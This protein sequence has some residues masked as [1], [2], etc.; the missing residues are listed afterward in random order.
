VKYLSSI[1]G[2]INHGDEE[3]GSTIQE[4]RDIKAKTEKK[5]ILD[6]V[7]LGF[8]RHKLEFKS[9]SDYFKLKINPSVTWRIDNFRAG[10]RI[11]KL[12]C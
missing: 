12:G 1:I 6:L 9:Y 3:S 4:F 5:G 7:I 8:V 10:R 11:K 2:V